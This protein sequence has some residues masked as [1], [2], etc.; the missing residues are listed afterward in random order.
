MQMQRKEISGDRRL[1]EINI[2][3]ICKR[4]PLLR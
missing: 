2:T 1:L 3:G 4:T